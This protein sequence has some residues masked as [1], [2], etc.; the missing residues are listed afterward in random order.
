MG[1]SSYISADKPPGVRT[2][3]WDFDAVVYRAACAVEQ[4][5]IRVI[6]KKNG[7]EFIF[8]NRTELWGDWRKKEGGW[9]ATRDDLTVEDLEVEDFAVA[10]PVENALSV[11]KSIIEGVM[12]RIE[13][14]D[15]HGYLGG[16][17][18]FRKDICTL[19]P[20][21]GNRVNAE[22][23]VHKD[24]V[25][26]YLKQY[27]FTEEVRGQE[28]DD[29]IAQNV[30]KHKDKIG[31]VLEKDYYGA[32]GRYYNFVNEEYFVVKGLGELYK[33]DKGVKGIGRLWKYFQVCYQDAIDN[34]YANCFSDQKNG[35]VAVYNRLKDC[36]TD[37]EAFQAMK[38]HF[39]Y[40][41]PEPK[42]ITNW[43]GDTFEID[44]MYVMQECFDLAHLLRFPNDRV[45]LRDAFK[46]QGIEV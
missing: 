7:E 15:Y 45:N 33:N 39:L 18:N 21:K 31:I 25:V 13:L 24:A 40:L 12:E 26:E 1:T 37:K 19:L 30:Y 38:D 22:P 46:K 9:L 35:E 6:S 5:Q 32:E 14:K 36:K 23:P 29:S 27:H 17:D 43:K 42:I 44:W 20:Y 11:A 10:E 28:T 4:R 16:R 41:Y 2:A 8:K 34:Y 3:V